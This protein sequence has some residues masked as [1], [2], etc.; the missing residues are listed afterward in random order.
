MAE[1]TDVSFGKLLRKQMLAGGLAGM[2]ADGV[3]YPMMT[4]KSRLM[5]SSLPSPMPKNFPTRNP[6]FLCISVRFLCFGKPALMKQIW[7]GVAKSGARRGRE[8]RHG[9]TVHV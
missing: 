7:H 3:M 5:V 2:L 4:V 9:R 8:R 6:S 1:Y